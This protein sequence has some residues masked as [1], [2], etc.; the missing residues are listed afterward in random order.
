M[1]VATTP[2]KSI[3][4]GVEGGPSS[5]EAA[6][7]AVAISSPDTELRFITVHTSFEPGPDNHRDRLEEGL[8]R[9]CQMADQSGVSAS[10]DM[11]EGR[12]ATEVLLS[13]GR[14]HD[15][16]VLGTQG[17]SRASGMV[18][19]STASE[20]AHQ[21]EHP[22]LIAR[23]P[24]EP[25]E[26]PK[27]I[28]FASDGTAGSWAP[29]RTVGQLA[30]AFD[31]SVEVLHVEDGKDGDRGPVLDE[32][33]AELAELAG[34]EPAALRV[35][36]PPVQV[37]IDAAKEREA[38]MIVCGRRG[39]R[40]IKALGSVSEKVVHGADCSVLLVPAGEAA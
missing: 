27:K 39:L 28:L 14:E 10:A 7:Q 32:Q 35:S 33:L 2:F 37:I 3:V 6:R 34:A 19:G 38:S 9:A 31:A 5:A 12:Y 17:S 20:T 22:V 21:A 4:C 26:F 24:P 8:T 29:A 40:G 25:R 1:E 30:A 11:K 23:E 16:L 18:F 36:G 15:L 13:E